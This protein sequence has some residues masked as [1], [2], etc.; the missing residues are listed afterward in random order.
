MEYTL[1]QFSQKFSVSEHTLRYYTDIGIL[2]CSRDEG[3]RRVFDDESANWLRAI[4]CLKNC[5]ASIKA[6][7]EYFALCRQS[8][9]KENLRARF[10]IILE[11]REKAYAKLEEAKAAVDYMD[12]KV[13]HYESIL[14]GELPD[15]TNPAQW[16]GDKDRK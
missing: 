14:A 10:D 7:T 4:T 2:P 11:Q 9:S 16:A 15:D 1:K 8:E 5:G 3:N 6:I 12:K 13:K